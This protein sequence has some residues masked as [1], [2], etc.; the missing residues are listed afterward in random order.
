LL[1]GGTEECTVAV[2]G[3]TKRSNMVYSHPYDFYTAKLSLVFTFKHSTKVLNDFFIEPQCHKEYSSC[4]SP[5]FKIS[6]KILIII[7]P[8]P[9]LWYQIPCPNSVTRV[10]FPPHEAH[11]RVFGQGFFGSF[12]VPWS[13]CSLTVLIWLPRKCKILFEG[14][15]IQ[16]WIFL[17]K[18]SLDCCR[19]T[20][21]LWLDYQ[22]KNLLIV[23]GA[24]QT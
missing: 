1:N 5:S 8:S 2:W 12:D 22:I 9:F 15:T 19:S 17:K 18:C 23:L 6:R 4:V 21:A 10:K 16:S 20:S 11:Q 13:N 3:H 7:S 14:L 24:C